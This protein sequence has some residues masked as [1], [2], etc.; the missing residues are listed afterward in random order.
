MP[1]HTH[2]HGHLSKH[3]RPVSCDMYDTCNKKTRR[4]VQSKQL[5][6]RKTQRHGAWLT[7]IWLCFPLTLCLHRHCSL[8][9][10]GLVRADSLN[11]H[12]HTSRRRLSEDVWKDL[13]LY[14]LCFHL[15]VSKLHRDFI[16]LLLHR[17]Q[18]GR[19]A[20]RKSAVISASFIGVASKRP[21]RPWLGEK[22]QPRSDPP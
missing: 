16:I 4:E 21:Q 8:C 9:T 3:H 18:A 7:E 13:W 11:I 2:T 14:W 6:V 5:Y 20:G 1:L 19:Q 17:T 15:V 22:T 10:K 12:K